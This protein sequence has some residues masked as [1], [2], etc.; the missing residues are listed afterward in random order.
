M[1][2]LVVVV[3][4]GILLFCCFFFLIEIILSKIIVYAVKKSYI[5]VGGNLNEILEGGSLFSNKSFS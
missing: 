1:D 5:Y 2:F 4:W 3:V